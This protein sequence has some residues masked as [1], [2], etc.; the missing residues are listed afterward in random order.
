[1]PYLTRFSRLACSG[2]LLFLAFS[3]C[4]AAADSRDRTQFGRNIT[5]GP[6]ESVSQATCFGCSIRV[7]GH[8]SGDVTTF[9]GSVL[10]ENQAEVGGDATTFAG[11]VR[12][13]KE[14]TVRG[15]VTVFGGRLRRDSQSSVGGDVTNM[16]GPGWIVLIFVLPL[17]VVGAF[18]ALIGWL[19]WRFVRRPASPAIA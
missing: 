13:D 5:I 10:L 11:D 2:I 12:L 3:L 16:S 4:A 18:L 14:A 6:D 1:M 9:G 8:V 7:Q 15:D 17:V 19:I